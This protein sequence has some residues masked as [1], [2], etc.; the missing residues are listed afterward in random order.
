MYIHVQCM[1]VYIYCRFV[2]TNATKCMYYTKNVTTPTC[3]RTMYTHTLLRGHLHTHTHNNY[4]VVLYIMQQL[5]HDLLSQLGTAVT[6]RQERERVGEREGE[7]EGEG[8]GEDLT[9]TLLEL[10]VTLKMVCVM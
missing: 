5:K 7:G 3:T 9:K 8:E 1:C 2:L 6:R 4:T 10:V